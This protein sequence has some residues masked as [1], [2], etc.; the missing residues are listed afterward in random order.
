MLI[1][2]RKSWSLLLVF[3]IVSMLIIMANGGNNYVNWLLC[4]VPLTAF[5]A[6]AY[7]YPTKKFFPL[8][9]HWVTFAYAIYQSYWMQA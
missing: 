7:F 8:L 9:I 3:L 1:Q 6:A 5:H 4:A 2:V